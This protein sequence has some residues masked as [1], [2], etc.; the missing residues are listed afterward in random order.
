M[1]L[2]DE[3]LSSIRDSFVWEVFLYFMSSW[4]YMSISYIKLG[5]MFRLLQPSN[6][7]QQSSTRRTDVEVG[8]KIEEARTLV[9]LYG[10][11]WHYPAFHDTIRIWIRYQEKE[12]GIDRLSKRK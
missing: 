10:R 1:T 7:L 4:S 6:Q 3:A 9:Q 2:Q 5:L 12:K 11:N 8:S